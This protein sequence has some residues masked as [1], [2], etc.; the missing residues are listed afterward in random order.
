MEEPSTPPK[1]VETEVSGT[2][3][4]TQS[5]RPASSPRTLTPSYSQSNL[6][7]PASIHGL[8][9][10]LQLIRDGESFASFS[11]AEKIGFSQ[12]INQCF[13]F[14]EQLSHLLPLDINAND[15]FEKHFDGLI[16][17]KI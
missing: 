17:C 2:P 8:P 9:E 12:H 16:L 6:N 10:D 13:E 14:D 15:L 5:V 4:A 7:R 11:P 1:T 3:V